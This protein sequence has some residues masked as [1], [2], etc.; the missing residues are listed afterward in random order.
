MPTAAPRHRPLALECSALL[1]PL[2]AIS[3]LCVNTSASSCAATCPCQDILS[4]DGSPWKETR[5]GADC[6]EYAEDPAD[7]CAGYGGDTDQFGR[8]ATQACCVCGG[9]TQDCCPTMQTQC[10]VFVNASAATTTS[11]CG[12]TMSEACASIQ[13]GIDN[14]LAGGMV[15]VSEGPE[16]P[17][18]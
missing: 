11:S 12:R 7:Y 3:L 5:F 14:A 6:A 16:L 9:G 17:I 13:Q 8:T 18:I 2:A 4:Q 1:F 10:T 15:C